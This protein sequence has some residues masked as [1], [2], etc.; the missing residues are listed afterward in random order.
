MTEDA[1][2]P[3]DPQRRQTLKALGALVAGGLGAAALSKTG[4]AS[5]TPITAGTTGR[6]VSPTRPLPLTGA[7]SDATEVLYYQDGTLYLWDQTSG[8]TSQPSSADAGLT[9]ALTNLASLGGGTVRFGVGTY[10][11]SSTISLQDVELSGELGATLVPAAGASL[12]TTSGYVLPALFVAAGNVTLRGLTFANPNSVSAQ[13]VQQSAPRLTI[14][15]CS[16]ALG[17]GLGCTTTSSG[18][19]SLMVDIEGCAFTEAGGVTYTLVNPPSP[20]GTKGYFLGGLIL[21]DCTWD[22]TV[23]VASIAPDNPDT[24]P[25]LDLTHW[26]IEGNQIVTN[27]FTGI[28]HINLGGTSTTSAGETLFGAG[29]GDGNCRIAGNR[30]SVESTAQYLIYTACISG[31]S[32]D[33]VGNQLGARGTVLAAIRMGPKNGLGFP[34]G[35]GGNIIAD[36]SIWLNGPGGPGAANGGI[37][38]DIECDVANLVNIENN[39]IIGGEYGIYILCNNILTNSYGFL[40]VGNRI[41]KTQYDNI[42]I[43]ATTGGYISEVMVIGNW[44][45]NPNWAKYSTPAAAVS[46]G[47]NTGGAIYGPGLIAWNRIST[48]EAGGQAAQGIFV[49]PSVDMTVLT[50]AHNLAAAQSTTGSLDP[51]PIPHSVQGTTFTSPGSVALAVPPSGQPT[52]NPLGCGVTLAV[53]GGAVSSILL[54][55]VTTGVASGLIP[56]GPRDTLVITYTVAPST[57][58][59]IVHD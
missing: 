16:L 42:Y 25:A 45:C 35:C 33:I 53:Q 55:G 50:L 43:S 28:A 15:R 22:A 58:V 54:N 10:A 48:H 8:T 7:P 1:V 46:L 27:A 29:G 30:I 17:V 57:F 39:Q 40:I 11:F 36:N 9:Q 19:D 44:L 38:I 20:L 14:E 32:P 13:A 12:T 23:S 59:A 4:F 3:E 26:N 5:A 24:V 18:I 47:R 31:T 2:P 56:W 34:T 49:G 6:T 41:D 21:R 52:V 37:G 51:T